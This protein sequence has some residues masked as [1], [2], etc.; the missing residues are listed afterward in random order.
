MRHD[1]RPELEL[2]AR[3]AENRFEVALQRRLQLRGVIRTRKPELELDGGHVAVPRNGGDRLGLAQR[4][5]Q[6]GI[7]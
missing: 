2:E 7:E 5:P 4:L 6:V 3:P 1:V